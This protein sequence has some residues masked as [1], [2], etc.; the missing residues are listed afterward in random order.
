M[1]HTH[2]D[3]N[4]IS[5]G[6][7]IEF[8][9]VSR[10]SVGDFTE[11]ISIHRKGTVK[12]ISNGVFYGE[13]DV[14]LYSLYHKYDNPVLIVTP[15]TVDIEEDTVIYDVTLNDDQWVPSMKWDLYEAAAL[16][17][18]RR[19]VFMDAWNDECFYP[20][21]IR[22]FRYNKSPLCFT[23]DMPIDER[24]KEIDADS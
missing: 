2:S 13:G 19:G 20:E 5:L 3:P 15:G 12:K 22:S 9:G 10:K 7:T 21:E 18:N 1:S 17:P 23:S 11:R 4:L 16:T 8:S 24:I 6:D 14:T